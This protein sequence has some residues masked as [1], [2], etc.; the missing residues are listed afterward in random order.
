VISSPYDV[1]S[2]EEQQF[3]YSRSP[4]NVVRLELGEELPSD[5]AQNNKYTRAAAMLKNWLE[6]GI[7]TREERPSFYL[8]Q[9]RFSH[10]GVPRNRWGLTA[11]VRV[12]DWSLGDIR[13][14]EVTFLQYTTDRLRL[15][16]ACR[17]NSS[18][19]FGIIRSKEDDFHSIL[20]EMAVG[21]PISSAEDSYGVTHNMWIVNGEA[22]IERIHRF[23]A[24]KTLYIADG[25]HRY[26]TSLAYQ[27]ERRAACT[28]FTGNEAFNFVMITLAD[29]RDPGLLI[30]PSHR[31]VKLPRG[32]NRDVQRLEERLKTDFYLEEL[33]GDASTS[34]KTVENWLN[35]LQERGAAAIGLYGLRGGSLLVLVPRN[36]HPGVETTASTPNHVWSALGVG[37]LHRVILDEI[38]EIAGS[39]KEAECV[40][41]TRDALEAICGVDSGKYQLAFLLN[42]IPIASV[43][44][45]A[46]VGDKMPQKSTHFYPKPPTGLVM[47]PVWDEE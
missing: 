18:P 14:H 27:K 10:R 38:I 11:R 44:E 12:Q 33:R 36:G 7:L 23:C 41:Y 22:E 35:T 17:V 32:Y 4:Y 30:L 40:E 37:I 3:Y 24:D 1:I 39:A 26:E 8:F 28:S 29:W 34:A 21:E 6:E 43:L 45:A 42:P 19:V 15:L 31:L 46:D 2:P 47:N 20:S 5:S 13:P 9:H 25:H 16:Q